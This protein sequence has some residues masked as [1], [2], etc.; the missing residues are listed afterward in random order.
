MT[1][2]PENSPVSYHTQPQGLTMGEESTQMIS[3]VLLAIENG[4]EDSSMEA[5]ISKEVLIY[6]EEGHVAD[7]LWRKGGL[8]G[9]AKEMLTQLDMLRMC[10]VAATIRL[11]Q[12]WPQ[13]GLMCMC[14]LRQ[15]HFIRLLPSMMQSCGW[16]LRCG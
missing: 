14:R 15:C 8:S 11:L 13:G 10:Q 6:E 4:C 5:E 3:N 7:A 9:V 12:Y 1:P 16:Q 2:S